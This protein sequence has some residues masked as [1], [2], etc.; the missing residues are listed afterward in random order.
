MSRLIPV[1]M[2]ALVLGAPG[3]AISGQSAGSDVIA[4]VR[5]AIAAQDFAR[6]DAIVAQFRAV[7]GTTPEA[8]A[9]LSWLGR[10][11]LAAKQFERADRYARETHKLALA[12]LATRKLDEDAHLQTALGAAIEVEAL[13][14]EATGDRSIAVAFL[15]KELDKY[16]DTA[17]HKR[18]VRNLN[19]LSLKGQPAPALDATEYLGRRVPTFP[20]LR[21]KV[22]LLFFWAHWCPDC[23]A[24]APIVAKLFDRY[25]S[26]GLTL[27]A[28]T[29]RFGYV[30]GGKPATPDEELRYI[31]E[32]RDT[33]Y[34]FLRNQP[35]PMS[36]SNHKVYGVA[37]TPTLVLV[38]RN[39]L[40]RLYH[41]GSITEA[42]LDTEIRAVLGTS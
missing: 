21:G 30:A 12:A 27:I 35:V 14:G 3:T 41:P 40:V 10:G 20:E 39:G 28:P 19:R 18:I 11:A 5:R 7:H 16:R 37:S 17:I 33:Q 24:E 32:I 9:A 1:F 8:L 13:V 36:E 4:E 29:Q 26:Q 6:A 15:R 31:T 22:V 2:L 34:G 42:A 23:K 38:D 25:Q